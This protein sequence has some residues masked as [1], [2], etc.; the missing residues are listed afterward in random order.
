[1]ENLKSPRER[2]AAQVSKAKQQLDYALILCSNPNQQ[3]DSGRRSK[4]QDSA[5]AHKGN[6][7]AIPLTP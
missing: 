3:L 5:K 4:Q 2:F 7:Y 6:G 1:M